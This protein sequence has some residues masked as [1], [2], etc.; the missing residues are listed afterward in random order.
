M[1]PQLCRQALSK[2]WESSTSPKEDSRASRAPEEQMYMSSHTRLWA[3]ICD[4][5]HQFWTLS[6]SIQ[7]TL[8]S[9]SPYLTSKMGSKVPEVS[10]HK[11]I[12]TLRCTR[13]S[14]R[15]KIQGNSKSKRPKCQ[16]A[17]AW[18]A[19]FR[20]SIDDTWLIKWKTNSIANLGSIEHKC[21][22]LPCSKS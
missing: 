1:I 3:P 18:E 8:H 19:R 22:A 17:K 16:Q 11:M 7:A 13:S 21:T 4:H 15:F 20:M 2:K 6:S 5:S 9:Y 14:L 12:S 10:K